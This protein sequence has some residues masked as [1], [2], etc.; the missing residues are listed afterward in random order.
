MPCSFSVKVD[1]SAVRT[2]PARNAR[3]NVLV[4]GERLPLGILALGGKRVRVVE[5]RRGIL[6]DITSVDG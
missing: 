5:S 2:C 4:P 3:E 6:E 1:I